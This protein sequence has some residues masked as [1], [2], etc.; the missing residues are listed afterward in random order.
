MTE[1]Y[2]ATIHEEQITIE[3]YD[4]KVEVECSDYKT[5]R[6]LVE[7]IKNFRV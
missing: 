5:F 7:H 3:Q 1:T 6:E 2:T 4:Y